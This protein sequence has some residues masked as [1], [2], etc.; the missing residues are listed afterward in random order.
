M[1]VDTLEPQVATPAAAPRSS[2]TRV[3]WAIIAVAVLAVGVAG[4]FYWGNRSD[5]GP[6]TPG[7]NSV[8]AGFA[9]DMA[10]HHQQAI[11]MAGYVR[12]H[13]NTL[14][15]ANSAYDIETAQSVQMGEMEGWLDDWGV[16]RTSG[17]PMSWMHDSH[18]HMGANGL[19]PGMAT[20]AQVNKLLS[21]HGKAMDILF[22][23]LMIHHHQG[24]VAM[25]RYAEAHAQEPYV[26]NLAGNMVATQ[27]DEIIQMEQMLRQLG[28]TMLPPPAI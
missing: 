8:D 22:L 6:S 2:L 5:S 15:V 25:A 27:S 20:P 3:L 9:R 23:Q 26:R 13:R 17:T 14:A 1:A 7:V 10:T 24:G 21:S 12:D 16:S 28:G 19:M 11:V 4:G 18:M